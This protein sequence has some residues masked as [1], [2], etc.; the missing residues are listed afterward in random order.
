MTKAN[1]I[2]FTLLTAKL[3]NKLVFMSSS[4][5]V[6]LSLLNKL[7]VLVTQLLTIWNLSWVN[8]V[9]LWIPSLVN[10]MISNSFTTMVVIKLVLL[11][12]NLTS[13]VRLLRLLLS[14]LFKVFIPLLK[15]NTLL[16]LLLLLKLLYHWP[17]KPVVLCN[18]VLL[19]GLDGIL[20]LSRMS[21][22]ICSSLSLSTIRIPLERVTAN[23]VLSFSKFTT[24]TNILSSVLTI[25]LIRRVLMLTPLFN[26]SLFLR[27]LVLPGVSTTLVIPI[28]INKL[29]VPFNVYL[30]SNMNILSLLLII[31]SLLNLPSKLPRM[32]ISINGKVN[33]ISQ[34]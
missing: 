18:M 12:L 15:E 24:N 23:L 17:L 28:L 30:V 1:G 11:V 22:V 21:V 33:S 32:L 4:K 5:V 6:N 16:R 34:P 19:V 2:G 27:R 31:L 10:S 14:D 3:C 8:L 7:M 25:T 9:L 26:Q 29:L 13:Q 20:V